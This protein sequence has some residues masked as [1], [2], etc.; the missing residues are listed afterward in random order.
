MVGNKRYQDKKNVIKPFDFHHLK[1]NFS[2][3]FPASHELMID[4]KVS[5]W[6]IVNDHFHLVGNEKRKFIGLH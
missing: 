3:F 5:A 1:W 6:H 2:Y 4:P